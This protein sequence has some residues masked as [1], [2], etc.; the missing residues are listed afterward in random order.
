[1]PCQHITPGTTTTKSFLNYQERQTVARVMDKLVKIYSPNY[2]DLFK[3][4]FIY[5]CFLYLFKIYN[6]FTHLLFRILIQQIQE[7][8]LKDNS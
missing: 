1:M 5:L 3:V 4:L 8:L 2:I 6:L 7:Q